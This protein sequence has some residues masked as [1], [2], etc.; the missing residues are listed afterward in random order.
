MCVCVCV[1]AEVDAIVYGTG[2]EHLSTARPVEWR[3]KSTFVNSSQ[4]HALLL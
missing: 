4:Q 1:G 3:V 2:K